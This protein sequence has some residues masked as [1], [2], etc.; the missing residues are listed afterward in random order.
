[1]AKLKESFRMSADKKYISAIEE[2]FTRHGID[3]TIM[4]ESSAIHDY[5]VLDSGTLERVSVINTEILSYDEEKGAL[6]IR[7]TLSDGTTRM[8]Y[9]SQDIYE[10][11]KF[12]AIQSVDTHDTQPNG[13]NNSVAGFDDMESYEYNTQLIN[14]VISFLLPYKLNAGV[15]EL[16]LNVMQEVLD[17]CDEIR[18]GSAHVTDET[19]KTLLDKLN[20]KL[21]GN[22]Q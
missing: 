3:Y 13:N 19:Y 12:P 15:Q 21:G 9:I 1:M 8:T 11:S 16:L 22:N 7:I 17:A 14:G 6:P 18:D 5:V 10:I 4:D 20:T 2:F